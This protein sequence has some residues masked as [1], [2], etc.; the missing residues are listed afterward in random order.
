MTRVKI[1]GITREEDAVFC[2]EAGADFL[3]VVFARNSTRRVEPQRAVEIAAAVKGRACLVGVFV[4]ENPA[5]VRELALRC[6]LDLVQLHGG[7][8]ESDL[9]AVGMPSIRAVR[10][11][12]EVPQVV[13]AADWLLFD[14][15]D[16][17][18]PAA[19][20]GKFDWSLLR[21]AAR[22]KPF[23]LA[24]GLT[25]ENVGDAIRIARPDAVDVSSGVE[26]APGIKDYD[27]VRR[28]LAQVK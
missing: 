18:A 25:P 15:R 11:S 24:G 3:G 16:P 19:T 6:G 27:M 20:G 10:V 12:E 21:G 1:C 22:T 2:A 7:V 23:F 4:D 9:A 17:R 14:S 26:S 8:S 28:F 13:T 5:V